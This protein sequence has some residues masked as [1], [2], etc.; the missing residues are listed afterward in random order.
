MNSAE[1]YILMYVCVNC[2]YFVLNR[3]Y[4]VFIWNS[5]ISVSTKGIS[6]MLI[7]PLYGNESTSLPLIPLSHLDLILLFQGLIK[8][9]DKF[10]EADA[11]M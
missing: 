5:L 4:S 1:R 9:F 11:R 3:I 7:K 2:N 6:R 8:F 10:F